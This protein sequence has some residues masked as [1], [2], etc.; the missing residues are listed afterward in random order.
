[1]RARG[2]LAFS[3]R[4]FALVSFFS[5]GSA[6]G[7]EIILGFPNGLAGWSTAGDSGTVT[8]SNGQATMSE[9]VFA[10]ETDLFLT[11]S[12]PTGPQSLQFTLASLFA[13][14]TLADNLANGY[15]PDA[16]GASLLNPNTGMPLVPTVDASTDSFYTRDVVDGVTQGQ[17]AIGVIVSPVS[18][19][20]ALISVDITSL[21]AGQQGEIFFRLLGGTDPSGTST[22]TLS[23]VKIV[24]SSGPSLPEPGS[25]LLAG[26][27]LLGWLGYLLCRP[28]PAP[29]F[30][31]DGI[32]DHSRGS[33]PGQHRE[34]LRRQESR[35][36]CPAC[37]PSVRLQPDVP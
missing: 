23:D 4:C 19:T 14:S 8:A 32:D 36:G 7:G 16:F 27:G 37:V 12:V 30:P 33:G 20:P 9:S 35:S 11:F 3:V 13:D 31:Q 1:M 2:L 29:G 6:T 10:T 21:A 34:L 18:G 22:V 24:T 28:R 25:F 15:L 5:T 26:L 17:A